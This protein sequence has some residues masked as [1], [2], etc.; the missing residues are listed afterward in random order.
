[1]GS[2]YIEQVNRTSMVFMVGHGRSGTTL[3]QS[4][5]NN[6]PN[7]VAPPESEF[8]I[9]LY[10]HFGKIRH[11]TKD[12]IT[13]FIDAL[14]FDPL[15]YLWQLNKEELHKRMLSAIEHL[16]YPLACKMVFYEMRKDKN[17]VLVLCDK[18]PL[19]SLFVPTLLTIFPDAKF[20]H[21]VREPRDSV[22]AHIN[23]MYAKN[24]FFLAQRWVGFNKQ[25]ETV[26]KEKPAQFITI[27]YEKMVADIEG[28]L[29][30]LYSFLKVPYSAPVLAQETSAN[31]ERLLQNP[32]LQNLPANQKDYILKK[33]T[34]M[35]SG[36]FKPVTTGNIEK[37]RKEMNPQ[38]IAITEI[39]TG[40]YAKDMYGY[41]VENSILKTNI[42]SF[43]LMKSKLKYL[44][45]QAFTRLRY[46]TYSFNR[47]YMVKLI[48]KDIERQRL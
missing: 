44:L 29:H 32:F 7:I 40:K 2:D 14:F 48:L 42:S 10:P 25:I 8:I 21:L 17:D 13:E 5:M 16:N 20:I 11:W 33:F 41:T 9:F 38:D 1:M 24:A 39:I 23:R 22:S 4:I 46:S 19:Y 18:K 28:V 36:H 45:W 12:D 47:R 37:W 27:L 34:T 30:Q 43:S 35:H 26:K 3:L 6:H 15:F 31:Y